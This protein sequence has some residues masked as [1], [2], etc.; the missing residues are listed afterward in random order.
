MLNSFQYL[1][2]YFAPDSKLSVP[3]VDEEAVNIQ[4]FELETQIQKNIGLASSDQT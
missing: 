3:N 1:D 2:I 4:M